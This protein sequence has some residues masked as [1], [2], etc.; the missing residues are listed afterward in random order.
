MLVDTERASCEAL[1]R[2]VLEVT[3]L[4]VPHN[5]PQDFYGVFGMDVRSCVEYYKEQLGRWEGCCSGRAAAVGGSA[6]CVCGTG[7]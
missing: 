5:F 2:A 4:D 3:G 6:C 1:R 7:C